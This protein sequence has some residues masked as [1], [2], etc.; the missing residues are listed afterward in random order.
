MT[1]FDEF[2]L[3]GMMVMVLTVLTQTNALSVWRTVL[4][5]HS[6]STQLEVLVVN[7]NLDL[8]VMEKSA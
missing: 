5:I 3:L 1:R 8:L 4:L 2:N 6:V 7:V